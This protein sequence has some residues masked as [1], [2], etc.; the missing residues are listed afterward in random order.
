MRDDLG[1]SN[2]PNRWNVINPDRHRLAGSG[3]KD[4]QGHG[5]LLHLIHPRTMPP[6]GL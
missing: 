2:L 3:I 6:A 4:G 5:T 1:W